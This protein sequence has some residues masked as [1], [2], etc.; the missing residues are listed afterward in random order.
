MKKILMT[1]LFALP[2]L[3]FSQQATEIVRKAYLNTE[4]K[5]QYAYMQMQVIRPKWTR[6]IEFKFVSQGTDKALVLITAPPKEQ[7][8]TFLL[9][10]GQMWTYNPRINSLVKIGPSMMS[11]G[12]M[13]SDYSNNELLNQGSILNDYTHKIIGQ[14][15]IDGRKCWKI[16]LQP[17]PSSSVVWGKQ[18]LWI[19]QQDYL[20][21]KQQLFDEDGYLVKTHIASDIKVLNGRK[22]PTKY[23]IIPEDTPENKTVVIIKDIKFDI[24]IPPGFFTIQ[25]MKRGMGIRFNF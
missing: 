23:T 22:I 19:D 3:V 5:S 13:G 2:V 15:T 10:N 7:G 8:Q 4:G 25:N 12:W 16:L 9:V 21:L 24:T 1:L 6:T 17:K 14:E 20:I 18:I 11:Q